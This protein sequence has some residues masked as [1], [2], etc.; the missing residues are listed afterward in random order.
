MKDRRN[1]INYIFHSL[2]RTGAHTRELLFMDMQLAIMSS[3]ERLLRNLCRELYS[4][5]EKSQMTVHS[6]RYECIVDYTDSAPYWRS[7]LSRNPIRSASNEVYERIELYKVLDG[8]AVVLGEF[9]VILKS[10]TSKIV[11]LVDDKE[12]KR[13]SGDP[14]NIG[15]AAQILTTDFLMQKGHFLVHS[16]AVSRNGRCQLWTGPGGSGKTTRVLEMVA[17]GWDFCGDDLVSLLKDDHGIWRVRPYKPTVQVTPDTCT[18]LPQL[19][20]LAAQKQQSGKYTFPI[21]RFFSVKIP[22]IATLDSI[23]FLCKDGM[24]PCQRLSMSE[25]LERLAPCFMYFLWPKDAQNVLD[26]LLDIILNIPVYVVSRTM[27]PLS[28]SEI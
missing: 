18:R 6:E 5:E 3:D 2:L 28:G 23:Y 24:D 8:F 21:D 20:N 17:E 27:S 10:N 26:A 12:G 4:W 15:T 22:R 13:Y 7:L 19:K 14:C 1:S 11:C 16:G 9:G 25:A